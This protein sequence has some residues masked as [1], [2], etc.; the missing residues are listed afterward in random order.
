MQQHDVAISV[1]TAWNEWRSL[2]AHLE[3]LRDVHWYQPLG[4]PWPLLHAYVSCG[5]VAIGSAAHQCD[6]SSAPHRIRVCVL[7][8]HNV[9]SAYAEVVR[10]AS[11]TRLPQGASLAHL[12]AR[13]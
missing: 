9:P 8:S 12:Q 2:I 11:H 6:P 5:S 7:K 10:R 4:A 1:T 3:D 13:A